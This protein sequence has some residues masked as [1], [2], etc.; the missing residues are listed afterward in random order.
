[1]DKYI[2]FSPVDYVAE[3][4]VKSIEYFNKN[5]SVLHIYNPNH[6]FIKDFIDL[7]PKKNKI[8][9]VSDLEF[10]NIINNMLKNDEKKYIISNIL[11]D[12]NSENKLVYDTPIKIGSDFTQ[13]FLTKIDFSWPIITKKYIENLIKN[14]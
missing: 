12:L 10:R 3:A 2:E 6:V 11:N 8:N 7:L 5:I 14:I 1:M 13:E 9:I 4:V